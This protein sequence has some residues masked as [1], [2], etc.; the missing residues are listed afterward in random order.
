MLIAT[1]PT[2]KRLERIAQ[3]FFVSKNIR[4]EDGKVYNANGLIDTVI[5]VQQGK[6][7]RLESK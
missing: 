5:V 3:D 6:R 1:A 4:I 2:I 7:F